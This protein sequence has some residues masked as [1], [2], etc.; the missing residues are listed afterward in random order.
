MWETHLIW[1][2]QAWAVGSASEVGR[3]QGGWAAAP[4]LLAGGDAV[5]WGLAQANQGMPEGWARQAD[6]P[7]DLEARLQEGI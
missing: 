3:Q 1:T 5:R 2:L 4:H 7:G 6:P